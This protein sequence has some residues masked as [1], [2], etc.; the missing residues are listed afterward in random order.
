MESTIKRETTS[1]CNILSLRKQCLDVLVSNFKKLLDIPLNAA[2]EET[3]PVTL[4]GHSIRPDK[5]LLK[6]PGDV[7]SLNRTPHDILGVGHE[8][9]RI[10]AGERKLVF[11][12][13]K[14]RMGVL[15]IYV[16]LLKELK[17][18][19][20]AVS[21]TD[22]FQRQQNFIILAVLLRKCRTLTPEGLLNRTMYFFLRYFLNVGMK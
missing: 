8:R 1:P 19:L 16:N 10:I 17:F 5:K 4:K 15:S 20:E 22:I 11:E 18:G 7:I 21:R 6:I 9:H 3:A 2:G 12:K 13:H 14:Q